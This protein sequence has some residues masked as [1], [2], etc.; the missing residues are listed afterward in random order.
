MIVNF[1]LFGPSSLDIM[2]YTF[3]KTTDWVTFHA[4]KQEVLLQIGEVITRHGAQIAFPTQTLHLAS[5]PPTQQPE[6]AHD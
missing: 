4:V 1:D 5:T 6:P 3:T 2:I